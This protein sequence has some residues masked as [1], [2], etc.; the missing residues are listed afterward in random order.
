[1][2]EPVAP[3]EVV[4]A[5]ST[6]PPMP[7][8]VSLPSMLP[9]G[10]ASLATMSTPSPARCGFPRCSAHSHATRPATKSTTMTPNSSQPWRGRPTIRPKVWV[11]AA[12]ST[13][14][15]SISSKFVSGVG[16]S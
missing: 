11:S 13:T 5:A 12:G 9:P 16:F 2:Y 14:M 1:M 7:N 15:A 4:T 3:F 10:W 8:R 6:E